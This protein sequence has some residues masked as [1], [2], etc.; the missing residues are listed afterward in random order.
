MNDLDSFARHLLFGAALALTALGLAGCET[1]TPTTA[2]VE[3]D[4]PAIAD[5]GDPATQTVVYRAWYASTLFL[6]PVAP[7]ATSGEQRTVPSTDYVYV[8]LAVGWDPTSG[9]PPTQ[10]V[11]LR[12][13]GQLGV[14]RGDLALIQVSPVRF[15]GDCAA[16][17]PLAQEDADFI[18]QRIFP[19]PFAGLRY[20]A[21]TCKGTSL[22]SDGGG[23]DATPE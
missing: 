14:S 12:S 15:D 17:S 5:G 7:G 19:G 4:Y 1:E 11:V 21:A 20:D 2:S 13:K 8:V 9:T 3:N 23:G 22:R 10:L 18:T 6:D 16:G